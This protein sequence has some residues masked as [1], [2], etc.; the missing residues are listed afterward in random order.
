MTFVDVALKR[1]VFAT[2]IIGG[3][4]LVLAA[5]AFGL[6]TGPPST[7]QLPQDNDV[8]EDFEVVQKAIGPGYEA[9]FVVIAATEDGTMTEQSRLASLARWQKR[10]AEDPAVQAVIGPQEVAEKTAPLKNAGNELHTTNQKGGQLYELNRLGPGLE[11]A[12]NG[13]SQIRTGLA[14]AAAGAGLLSEGSGTAEEGALSIADGLGEAIAG[15]TRAVTG[16]EKLNN[17]S[18]EISEGQEE[19]ALGA[20]SVH[21]GTG[22]VAKNLRLQVRKRANK[23]KHELEVLKASNP[24][25]AKAAERS[26]ELFLYIKELE[27]EA[28]SVRKEAGELHSGEIKLSNGNTHLHEGT[29][30]LNK[31]APALPEGLEELQGGTFRLANGISRLQGGSETLETNLSDGFHRSYPLQAR[32]HKASVKVTRG[33]GSVTRKVNRLNTQSPG[34]F[35]S[36]YFVLSAIDGAPQKEREKAGEVISIKNG[37]QGAAIT[38]ISKYTFNTPGSK[39]LDHRLA[40]YAEGLGKEAD[41]EAGVAGGA[42]QLT[43]YDA[44]TRERIPWVVVAITLVTLLVMIVIVRAPLLAAL[45]VLLNLATVGV[46][47]G[48]IV[49]LFN[50]PHGYPGGGHTYVDAIGA[51]AMFGVVFGLSIDYAVFL[52]MRMKENYD[53]NG[54]NAAA[55]SDGLEKT[56]RLITGAAAIMMA[57]FIAFAAAPIATVS[58]LGIGLT[59]AVLLDATVIRIVLLPALMLLLGDR[60]WHVPKWLDR[61]LPELNVEGE[62]SGSSKVVIGGVADEPGGA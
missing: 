25:V 40:G 38:V 51:V 13:V 6:K 8:R 3:I 47:F 17:G 24:E 62:E 28:V 41:V 27:K 46:A 61:I 44:I 10:I 53:R 1:P 45:A 16:I 54:D 37:G 32:L 50:V 36:G 52:L 22:L 15:G 30:K 34:L 14:K 33:A 18:G 26:L 20:E 11:R 21:N 49:L 48:V 23:L 7:E 4:V 57:V 56:A 9:P 2:V 59:V 19:A 55:I 39:H 43:D 60:V 5:P 31:E 42:A 58:Q 12:A 29:E 35:D